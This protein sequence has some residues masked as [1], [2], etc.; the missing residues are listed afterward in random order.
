M[1]RKKIM[2][3][4]VILIVEDLKG[5]F[6]LK[7]MT[8]SLMRIKKQMSL[9]QNKKKEKGILEGIIRLIETLLEKC[10]KSKE[11]YLE[12]LKLLKK[13]VMIILEFYLL[14]PKKI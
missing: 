13:L 14:K 9:M 1:I 10:L 7:L 8:E 2:I 3:Y 12:C 4:L 11:K 6:L 5:L